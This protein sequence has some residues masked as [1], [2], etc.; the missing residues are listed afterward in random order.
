MQKFVDEVFP[1]SVVH[2]NN[3]EYAVGKARAT[4][5]A[6]AAAATAAVAAAVYYI[7]HPPTNSL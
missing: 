6:A 7:V 2:R 1:G 5:A 3:M 4:S